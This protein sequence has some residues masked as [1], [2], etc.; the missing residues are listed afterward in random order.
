VP[1]QT[2]VFLLILFSGAFWSFRFNKL[3]PAG[4]VAGSVL[5]LAL[6]LG[7]GWTGF[8]L[9]TIFFVSGTAATSWKRSKK[10]SIRTVEERR[11]K[12]TASQVLA[13]GGAGGLLGFL[14]WIYPQQK[15]VF[16][17]MIAAAFSSAAAD[18][19][20]S[21]LGSVYGKRFYN[22]LSLKK[23][24]RGLDGVV[25]LEGSLFGVLGSLVIAT[26]YSA[27]FGWGMNFIRI[28]IAGTAGN[29]A[30]SILGAMFERRGLLHNDMVNF[31]NTVFAVLVCLLLR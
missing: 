14:A 6:Y 24:K 8:L 29:L 5:G 21:E 10:Q 4:V 9:M 27:G 1:L 17:L 30:D 2:L 22:I 20:S 31:L 13:N 7:G 15:E 18:T 28:V 19:L 16:L 3:T 23:D 26:V 25:S 12:R 11:G